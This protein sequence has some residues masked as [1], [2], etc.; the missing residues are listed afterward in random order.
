MPDAPLTLVILAVIFGGA[1]LDATLG[2]CFFVFGEIFFLLAGGLAF[3]H[4]SAAPIIAALAGAYLAD[5]FGYLIGRTGRSWFRYLALKTRRR[6]K[7]YRRVAKGLARRTIIFIAASRLMGPVA[8]ITPPF[9]GAMPVAYRKF[10]IGSAFGVVIG[11]G[12]FLVIGW[13]MAYGAL[14]AGFDPGALLKQY[15]WPIFIGVNAVFALG[16]LASHMLTR[17]RGSS[18]TPSQ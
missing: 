18:Q 1:F 14:S 8:W 5:Q 11:V 9:A 16:I 4:G 15:F 12:Q 13:L 6:R 17:G 7:A 3:T 2:F 10:V